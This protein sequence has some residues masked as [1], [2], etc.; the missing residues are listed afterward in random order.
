[1]VDSISLATARAYDAARWTQDEH[2]ESI[3]SVHGI[4]KRDP[5]NKL[6]LGHHKTTKDYPEG[7]PSLSTKN[8]T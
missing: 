2:F 8:L 5:G 4:K 6:S 3:E 7:S 1:M